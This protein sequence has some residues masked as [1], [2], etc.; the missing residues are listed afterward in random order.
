MPDASVP[1]NFRDAFS[2]R[3]GTDVTLVRDILDIRFG[4]FWQSSAYP[5]NFETFAVDF[6]YARE[7]GLG[8][9]ITVHAGRRLDFDAG[10]L[11]IFQEKVRVSRGIVQQQGLPL[12]SGEQIGNV[13]NGGLYEVGLNIFSLAATGHFN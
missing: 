9:G 10:Y 12:D 6:P 3:F 7:I 13:V 5:E 1:K 11:H 8:A 2:V 4:G